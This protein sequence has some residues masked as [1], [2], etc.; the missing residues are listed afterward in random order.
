MR[1]TTGREASRRYFI[2]SAIKLANCAG[3]PLERLRHEFLPRWHAAKCPKPTPLA[4]G[5]SQYLTG[6]QRKAREQA[7]NGVLE[8]WAEACNLFSRDADGN[9]VAA[10]WLVDFARGIC[11]SES[12]PNTPKGDAAVSP[13]LA[14]FGETTMPPP[15]QAGPVLA[16]P[17]DHPDRLPKETWRDFG[18]RAK[19][20]LA[21]YVKQQEQDEGL[22]AQYKA[23]QRKPKRT[24]ET[25]VSPLVHFE[26]FILYQCCE[27]K[28][29]E[30]QA[31]Y[32]DRG[33][34]QTIYQGI[35]SAAARTGLAQIAKD[36]HLKKSSR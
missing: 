7:A 5:R 19:K 33:S 14:R 2:E 36:R 13:R 12:T 21:K 30:I 1:L 28:L 3:S 26:W 32:P 22:L 20:A 31:A 15:G 17:M 25:K 11:E 16:I 23:F 6:E 8:H 29:I 9:N 35:K 24:R 4:S 27:W 10:D 18:R 34:P